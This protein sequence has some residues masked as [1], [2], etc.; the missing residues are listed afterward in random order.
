[1]SL[2]IKTLSA[3][4][5]HESAETTLNGMMLPKATGR[6]KRFEKCIRTQ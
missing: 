2:D 1:M 6:D 4:P 3:I 5:G